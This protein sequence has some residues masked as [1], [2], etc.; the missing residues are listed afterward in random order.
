[1]N[2]VKTRFKKLNAF[3]LKVKVE[4][5]EIKVF[6]KLNLFLLKLKNKR[7]VLLFEILI[8]NY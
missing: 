3:K 4:I 8:L 1:M 5:E 2:C 7:K 6:S